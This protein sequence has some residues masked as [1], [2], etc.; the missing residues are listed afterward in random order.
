MSLS[1]VDANHQ[2]VVESWRNDGIPIEDLGSLKSGLFLNA[3]GAYRIE[4]DLALTASVAYSEGDVR[5]YY[6]DYDLTVELTRSVGFTDAMVGIEYYVPFVPL[7]AEAY[8]GAE[9]GMMFARAHA[10]TFGTE[11]KM[12]DTTEMEVVLDSRGKYRKSK[13]VLNVTAGADVN[14]LGPLFARLEAKYKFGKIGLMPGDIQRLAGPPLD[15]STVEFDF[16]GL[17]LSVG[18]GIVF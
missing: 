16:S 1:Q 13:L 9:M 7:D 3:R 6:E 14:V 8:I 4:R 2:R 11:R 18:I 5:A 12:T 15:E 10:T 17:F